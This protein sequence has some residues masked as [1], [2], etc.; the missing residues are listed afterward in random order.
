MTVLCVSFSIKNMGEAIFTLFLNV[1]YF[2]M[3][4]KETFHYL[5]IYNNFAFEL[6][7][8]NKGNFYSKR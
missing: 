3:F 2:K 5:I 8:P 7:T 1:E 6:K 4:L